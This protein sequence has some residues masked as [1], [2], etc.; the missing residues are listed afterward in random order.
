MWDSDSLLYETAED[1]TLLV[2]TPQSDNLGSF[3]WTWEDGPVFRGMLLDD[4]GTTARIG[5]IET[6]T[7]FGWVKTSKTVDLKI[8]DAFRR[9]LDGVVFR[10]SD[11]NSSKT[12][13]SSDMDLKQ[14]PV[15]QWS[16]PE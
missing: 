6:G 4:Q 15:E 1:F 3:K 7:T 8:H 5:A 14:Y 2:R 11:K 12:P 9:N 10:V 13:P 16:I